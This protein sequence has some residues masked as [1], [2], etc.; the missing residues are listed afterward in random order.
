VTMFL[1]VLRLLLFVLAIVSVIY[2]LVE[3]SKRIALEEEKNSRHEQ[4][5]QASDHIE[6][7]IKLAENMGQPDIDRLK[8]AQ[9]KINLVLNATKKE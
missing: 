1:V 7:T 8:R 6:D 2:Y 3:R 4:L 5:K 9:E